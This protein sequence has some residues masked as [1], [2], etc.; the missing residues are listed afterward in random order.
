MFQFLKDRFNTPSSMRLVFAVATFG[1]VF[2]VVGVFTYVGLKT[3]TVPD[4]P[5]GVVAFAVGVITAL[6]A[7]KVYQTKVEGDTNV[8]EAK[9][10][11][12]ATIAEKEC[13]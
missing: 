8:A 1:I 5:S 9:V 11:V 12:T 3:V 10:E 2:S 6:A 13:E 7:A 4:I